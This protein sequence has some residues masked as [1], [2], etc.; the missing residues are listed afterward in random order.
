MIPSVRVRLASLAFLC[1]PLA[2]GGLGPSNVKAYGRGKFTVSNSSICGEARARA[3]AIRDANS[4]CEK[5]KKQMLPL[6]ENTSA[7][8]GVRTSFELVFS[9][10]E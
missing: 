6:D 2:C 9:C 1:V 3:A 10:V 4:F 5:Q 7:W 8:R